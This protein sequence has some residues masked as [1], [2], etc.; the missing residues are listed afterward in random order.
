MQAGK[1]VAESG[2]T[3]DDLAGAARMAPLVSVYG[4]DLD[5][6]VRAAHA[7]TVITHADNRVIQS[8][9]FFARTVFAVLGQQPPVAAME[10]TLKA[11]FSESPIA[12]LIIMG[13]NSRNRETIETIVEFGQMCNVE[14]GLPGA[15]H[16]IARHAGDFKT[17]MVENV[18][19]G[20][21]SSARGMMA[22]MVLGAAHGLAAIPDAWQSGMNARERIGSLL[23]RP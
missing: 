22:G 17:A 14:A 16:L 12:P 2:S 8:A 13:L 3:S 15:V 21:D 19:A 11:N 10:A 4:D 7:Q 5:Q 9:E 1:G 6:L 20:G 23:N 18:M